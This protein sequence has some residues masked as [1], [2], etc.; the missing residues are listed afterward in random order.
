MR[1]VRV[2]ADLTREELGRRIGASPRTIRRLEDDQRRMTDRERA[3]IAWACGAPEWFLASGWE[4][5]QSPA[6][7]AQESQDDRDG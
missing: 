1:A 3:R 5:A 2:F 6:D 7:P 4:G